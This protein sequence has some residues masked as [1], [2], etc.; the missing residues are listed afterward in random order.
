[1]QPGH[2]PD[3]A[4]HA[5]K[6]LVS[7]FGETTDRDGSR[8]TVGLH[9]AI[10]L[11]TAA[12]LAGI[13][14]YAGF[15]LGVTRQEEGVARQTDILKAAQQKLQ[16]QLA[17]AEA[18]ISLRD[19]QISGL[20]QQIHQDIRDR[21]LIRQRLS[22]FDDVLAARTVR[23][24]HVLHPEA[25]WQKDEGVIEY[26]LVLVKGEN[27]PRWALG[28]L[29]FSTR[30]PDG[31]ILTLTNPHGRTDIKYEMT[32]HLFMEGTLLW[33]GNTPPSALHVTLINH[34]GKKIREAE[35]PVVT[36]AVAPAQA[37]P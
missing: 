32:T 2:K 24:V 8:R 21:Q 33:H 5:S 18:E 14:L 26:Q 37:H 30:M 13:A 36:V 6:P 35:F 16:S 27:Y 11:L 25:Q 31:K 7:P 9:P 20:K 22:M 4:K 12:L 34:R 1:M 29:Q 19:S 3:R 17:S 10:I 28:H 23:G 15:H